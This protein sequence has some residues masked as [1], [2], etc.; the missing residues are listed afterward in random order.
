MSCD[1]SF[2]GFDA[3]ARTP[4]FPPGASTCHNVLSL[5]NPVMKNSSRSAPGG[6]DFSS[7]LI[8]IAKSRSLS[9]RLS[10][11]LRSLFPQ[12]KAA[13]SFQWFVKQNTPLDSRF[14]LYISVYSARKE[15]APLVISHVLYRVGH[16]GPAAA[17]AAAAAVNDL[18]LLLLQLRDANTSLSV[19]WTYQRDRS[20]TFCSISSCGR[21]RKF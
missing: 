5:T 13:A 19:H 15:A 16:A 6:M 17:A 10:G 20:C 8:T 12:A 1:N 7:L 3:C 21:N 14:D 11:P 9:A 4:N 18:I 2:C